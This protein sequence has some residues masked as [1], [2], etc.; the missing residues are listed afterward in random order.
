[1]LKVFVFSFLFFLSM[2]I[3]NQEIVVDDKDADDDDVVIIDE[4]VAPNS[5]GKVMIFETC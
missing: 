5:K 3:I 4:K 1:M 2:K